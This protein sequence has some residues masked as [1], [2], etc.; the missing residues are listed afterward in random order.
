MEGRWKMDTR[1]VKILGRYRHFKGK[2]YQVLLIA[3]EEATGRRVVV[4]QALYGD[5][6]FFVRPEEEFLSEVDHVKYPGVAARY[7][8]EEVEDRETTEELPK[9][10]PA[11][12]KAQVFVNAAP[13]DSTLDPLVEAFL[14]AKNMQEKL[15]ALTALRPRITNDMIDTMAVAAGL[16][17]G[18]GEVQKRYEDLRDCLLTIDRYEPPRGRLRG[19]PEE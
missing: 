17:I 13:E 10:Q 11:A 14:D 19:N 3:R 7:R 1:K 4:Y 6:G 9:E 8:F 5:Y 12:E 2:L 18:P 15:D 16:E